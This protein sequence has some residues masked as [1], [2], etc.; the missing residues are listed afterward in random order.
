MSGKS[1]CLVT[2]C[3]VNNIFG[4]SYWRISHE[5]AI[6]YWSRKVRFLSFGTRRW[7]VA[8]IKVAAENGRRTCRYDDE[9]YARVHLG[10]Q[11]ACIYARIEDCTHDTLR[12]NRCA[13]PSADRSGD[14]FSAWRK[15]NARST[16]LIRRPLRTLSRCLAEFSDDAV[17]KEIGMLAIRCHFNYRYFSFRHCNVS[18]VICFSCFVGNFDLTYFSL[19]LSPFVRF[20]LIQLSTV[21]STCCL[22]ASARSVNHF[23]LSHFFIDSLI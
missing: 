19:S 2:S 17:R 18:T 4:T 11:V 8:G 12:A 5:S 7:H 6:I 22:R 14:S 13:T 10:R 3:W 9:I 21:T 23:A 20:Y 16:T 1:G 15:S